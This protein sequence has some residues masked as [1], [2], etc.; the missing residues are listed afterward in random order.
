MPRKI[1]RKGLK[2]KAW[3]AFSDY[4][5]LRDSLAT[6][7]SKDFCKCVTCGKTVPYPNIQAGHAIGGRNNSILFDEEL[8]NGQC[9]GCN[10]YRGGRYGE[11]SVWFIK[12]YG[13]ELW[14]EKVTLSKQVMKN[15]D[16]EAIYKEYKEKIKVLTGV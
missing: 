4:I 8:V 15:L 3:K 12:K 9:K 16:L 6:T 10:G 11:Y 13:M 14:E 2:R 7:R 1:S 5:R